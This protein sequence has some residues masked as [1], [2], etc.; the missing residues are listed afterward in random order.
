MDGLVHP[1]ARILGRAVVGFK[2]DRILR[3]GG[4]LDLGIQLVEAGVISKIPIAIQVQVP[5]GAP[6]QIATRVHGSAS[7]YTVGTVGL[8]PHMQR[9]WIL[10]ITWYEHD[11]S[12]L[13]GGHGSKHFTGVIVY[14]HMGP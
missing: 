1:S 10:V 4:G 13:L 2:K 6:A 3:L 12:I 14:A 8:G 5:V 11:D 9:G 7:R